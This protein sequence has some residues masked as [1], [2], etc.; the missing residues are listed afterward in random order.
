MVMQERQC[1]RPQQ[2]VCTAS[3]TRPEQ[4]RHTSDSL[5]SVS[6]SG[7]SQRRLDGRGALTRTPPS[8]ARW[9][10]CGGGRWR[11]RCCV[12]PRAPFPTPAPA[13]A[14]PACRLLTRVYPHLAR[15]LVQVGVQALVRAVVDQAEGLQAPDGEEH[16]DERGCRAPR[17]RRRGER[18]RA[19]AQNVEKRHASAPTEQRRARRRRRRGGLARARACERAG[20]GTGAQRKKPRQA[21]MRSADRPRRGRERCAPLSV[22]EASPADSAVGFCT[23]ANVTPFTQAARAIS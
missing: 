23:F 9:S 14:Q 19:R 4:M 2:G 20:T 3:T 17:V 15:L 7:C 16:Q 21:C 10:R 8:F 6:S 12:T 22:L 5:M 13:E 11:R 1:R 18:E